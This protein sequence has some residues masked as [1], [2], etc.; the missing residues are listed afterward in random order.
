M[1]CNKRQLLEQLK[2]AKLSGF[3]TLNYKFYV[4]LLCDLNICLSLR[5]QVSFSNI[6]DKKIVG[7]EDFLL[8]FS[9]IRLKLLGL[10]CTGVP[11]KCL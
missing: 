6:V 1:S 10:L 7:Q 9:D 8:F 11:S 3:C 4:S 2:S 5:I